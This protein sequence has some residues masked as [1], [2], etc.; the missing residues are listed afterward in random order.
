MEEDGQLLVYHLV[1][2]GQHQVLVMFRLVILLKNENELIMIKKIYKFIYL[3]TV[4]KS[5]TLASTSKCSH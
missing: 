2:T 1:V 4:L 5:R 3:V